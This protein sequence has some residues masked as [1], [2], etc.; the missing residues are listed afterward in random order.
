MRA[1]AIDGPAAAGKTTTAKQIAAELGYTYCDTGALYRALAVGFLDKELDK[2][3]SVAEFESI[4]PHLSVSLETGKEGEQHVFLNGKDVT[5]RLRT[6]SVSTMAS[7]TSAIPAVRA[8]L[9]QHQK[10][11]AQSCSVVMEGRDIGTVILPQADLKVFLTA[12]PLERARRRYQDLTWKG[13]VVSY[14]DVLRDMEERDARDSSRAAAP[15]KPAP[16]AIVVNNTD[17]SV[18][19][20][21]QVIIDLFESTT[22]SG[23][24]DCPI[25]AF[26]GKYEFLSNFFESPVTYE[27][28]QYRSNEAAFQAAKTLDVEQRKKFVIVDPKTAK[29]MGRRL[30]LRSDWEQVKD[31]IMLEIL[32]A[33]F[34]LGTKNAM[35]LLA[36]G[37]RPLVE[38]NTWHDN[39]WGACRCAGC[40]GKEKIN[41]LG[42]LLE[43]I[44]SELRVSAN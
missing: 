20:T 40:V 34:A 42:K 5:G 30:K 2:D 41:R 27:G 1:I 18:K 26:R 25:S 8:H 37:N 39:Y 28:I 16:D 43:K 17:L 10:S 38:G 35:L 24:D 11:L 15:L 31:G 14:I 44:R 9:K 29:F 36:T 23:Q 22:D 21:V 12:N 7:I 3:S 6:E 33:K 4:L 13:S 19:E 32:R